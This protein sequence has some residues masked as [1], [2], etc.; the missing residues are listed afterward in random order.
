[1][2]ARSCT[3]RAYISAQGRDGIEQLVAVPDNSY[4]EVLG[5]A[6][7]GP[8][9]GIAVRLATQQSSSGL[10]CVGVRRVVPVLEEGLIDFSLNSEEPFFRAS[11]TV[12]KMVCPCFKF[13]RSFLGLLCPRL[14]GCAL[15]SAARTCKENLCARL[16]ARSQSDFA[17]SA[18]F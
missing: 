12:A 2:M 13:A 8:S 17:I 11:R 10:I 1:M 14:G 7:S 3:V 5:S 16:M 6:D 9:L 15:S 18:A 4:A